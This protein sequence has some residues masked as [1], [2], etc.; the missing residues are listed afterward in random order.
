LLRDGVAFPGTATVT[1]TNWTFTDTG[2]IN[3]AHT[4]TARAEQGTVFSATSAGYA[5]TIDTVAPTQTADV[6]LISDDISGALADGAST[7]DTTPTVSGTLS[8]ALGTN[9][10][11]QI[12]RGGVV[13][14]TLM[15][16]ATTWSHT[17]PSA[18]AAGSYLYAA[19]V[20]DAS[21]NVSTAAGRTRSVTISTAFPLAGAATAIS[22][23]NGV[24]P[25]GSA[26]PIN[27]VSSPVLA[28]TIERVLDTSPAEVVRIYRSGTAVGNATV[29]GT[30]WGFTSASL[31]DGTYT[32]VARIEVA[33]NAAVFGQPS[34]SI[35][36]P[37]DA[38]APAQK[39]TITATS[40]VAPS[41][42]VA[43]AVPANNNIAG[44]TNDPTPTV[45]ILLSAAMAGN[46]TLEIRRNNA[47]IKP[48][49]ASCGTN[50]LRFTDN[51]GVPIAVPPT[52]PSALPVENGYTARVIDSAGNIGPDGSLTA[53]FNYFTC[54]QV[55]ANTT[56]GQGFPPPPPAHVAISFANNRTLR[57]E[58]CHRTSP[59]TPTGQ[60][61][62][63]GTFVAVPSTS[64]SYWCRRPS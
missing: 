57:C 60:G 50:C 59:V 24:T 38:T 11:L 39:V 54:D 23:I 55:R 13:V 44:Q 33:G 10:S 56:F 20:A 42:T 58:N 18:V 4:Y 64:A 37:I 61:T 62:A 41:T 16:T 3:G 5:F 43:G 48:T 29:T 8:A 40:D 46:E 49:L 45:T 26:V 2:A 32:F 53:S 63:A 22:T 35:N 30:S 47:V 31:A 9:E 34:A 7:S 25:T 51:P 36:D 21:G 14:A 27:R 12:V 19:R 17:E 15:P 1:A 6:T 28:G 52:T